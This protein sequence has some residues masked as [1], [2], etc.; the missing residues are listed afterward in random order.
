MD[1]APITN[2]NNVYLNNTVTDLVFS[3]LLVLDTKY[4][5]EKQK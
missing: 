1:K 5:W 2:F 3:Q 4:I